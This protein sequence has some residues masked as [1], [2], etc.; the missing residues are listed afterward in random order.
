MGE[1]GD[2]G[3]QDENVSPTP[4]QQAEAARIARRQDGGPGPGPRVGGCELMRVITIWATAHRASWKL[5]QSYN[6]RSH[7]R[8]T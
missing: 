3:C 8:S 2:A 5:R 4:A 6:S 7:V 1:A